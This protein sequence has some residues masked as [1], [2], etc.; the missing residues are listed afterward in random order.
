MD[1]YVDFIIHEVSDFIDIVISFHISI[2]NK[3]TF[4]L[5]KAGVE[6]DISGL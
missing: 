2:Y 5:R 4:V 6:P 3:S 1:S